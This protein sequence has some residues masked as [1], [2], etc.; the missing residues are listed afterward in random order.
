MALKL[1]FNAA[2]DHVIKRI[3]YGEFQNKLVN[4]ISGVCVNTNYPEIEYF[5]GTRA[6]RTGASP[7]EVSMCMREGYIRDDY[8]VGN[9]SKPTPR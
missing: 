9:H 4:G 7:V 1:I 3:V 5:C 2:K 6:V 8:H